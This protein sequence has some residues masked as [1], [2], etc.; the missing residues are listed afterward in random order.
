MPPRA[1]PLAV[2]RLAPFRSGV[3]RKCRHKAG[4]ANQDRATAPPGA[5]SRGNL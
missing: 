2:S 4:I 3:K 1:P 5:A